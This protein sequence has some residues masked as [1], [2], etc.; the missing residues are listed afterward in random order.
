MAETMK[1]GRSF[2]AILAVLIVALLTLSL[3]AYYEVPRGT[4]T[5]IPSTTQNSVTTDS[6]TST[7]LACSAPGV[8]CGSLNV[9]SISLT[10]ASSPHQ[11]STLTAVVTNTGNVDIWQVTFYFN[12]TLVDFSQGIPIGNTVTYNVP[13]LPSF[14]IVSGH[15]YKIDVDSTILL[16]GERT[17]GGGGKEIFVTSR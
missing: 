7:T 12:G 14:S 15:T 10:A 1:L 5:S 3:I 9:S 6:I 8:Q 2:A 16:S 17:E 13:I 4:R 11:N